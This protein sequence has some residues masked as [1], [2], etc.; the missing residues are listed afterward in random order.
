MTRRVL[1]RIAF[2]LVKA[3]VPCFLLLFVVFLVPY[4]EGQNEIIND[5]GA[6]MSLAQSL[7]SGEGYRDI[8]LDGSPA[9]TKYPP[10]FPL[11]LVPVIYLCGL[12]LWAIRLCI[13]G[14]GV[15]ALYAIYLYFR[16]VVGEREAFTILAL[17][18]VSYGIWFYAQSIS[19]EMPYIFFSLLA[20]LFIER[21]KAEQQGILAKV[22]LA[23]LTVGVASLTRTLGLALL[24]GA[25]AHLAVEGRKGE[26][27]F[28]RGRLAKSGLFA[29][30]GSVPMLLWLVRNWLVS[31][32]T[33]PVGYLSEYGL[34]SYAFSYA[35]ADSGSI[36]LK[37]L[38]ELVYHNLYVY[39]MACSQII[40]PYFN[41]FTQKFAAVSLTTF[42]LIGFFICLIKRRTALEYYVP[43]YL[44]ALLFFP[45][46]YDRY[47]VPLI[48]IIFYY[49]LVILYQ[50]IRFLYM[51]RSF[52]CRQRFIMPIYS[53]VIVLL[54]GLNLYFSTQQ[55][56]FD[57]D[58]TNNVRIDLDEQVYAEAIP[59]VVEHTDASELFMWSKPGLR[60]LL[61]KR[62]AVLI[63]STTGATRVLKAIDE[64]NVDY[65]VIDSFSAKAVRYLKP[66]V[67]KYPE[68][69]SLLHRN[70]TSTIYRVER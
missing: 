67:T 29:S 7:L 65:V 25:V 45:A 59:W 35:S 51:Q 10:I 53:S 64:H 9:H 28:S 36:G 44:S 32:G 20:L 61:S 38:L 22:W 69:F 42:V 56:I 60:Y 52:F 3:R 62:K 12:N 2:L 26:G 63:P 41:G 50:L 23:A 40:F 37:G 11:L 24:V 16:R 33:A 48:P 57:R 68:R 19:S 58:A 15:L 31:G 4:L 55:N 14:L 6:Y 18:G 27:W 66:M 21:Y 47:L 17:T 70:E 30:L 43:P 39:T 13:V 8:F 5:S 46:S 54:I 49:F 34:K 1:E